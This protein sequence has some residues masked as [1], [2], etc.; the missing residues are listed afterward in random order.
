MT[1]SLA[2][3]VDNILYVQKEAQKIIDEKKGDVD[4]AK[5]LIDKLET[6]RKTLV[7][8]KEGGFLTGEQQLR[9]KIS[10]VYTTVVYFNGKP[11]VS[12]MQRIPG[13]EGEIKD[14]DNKTNEVFGKYLNKLGIKLNKQDETEKK[15]N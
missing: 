1:E 13:L 11:N 10:D 3:I 12:V 9:E 7:A 14:A 6:I 2:D 5:E 15:A 8:T 4:A